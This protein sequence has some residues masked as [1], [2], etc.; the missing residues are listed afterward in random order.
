M[1]PEL[2]RW[3]L[4]EG[5]SELERKLL[6][7]GVDVEPPTGAER[8]IWQALIAKLPPPGGGTGTGPDPTAAAGT[9]GGAAAGAAGAAGIAKALLMGLA[10]GAVVAAGVGLVTPKRTPEA[11]SVRPSAQPAAGTVAVA[12]PV[13]ERANDS[14]AASLAPAPAV[15]LAANPRNVP[16]APS[17][18][19]NTVPEP[20]VA[21]PAGSAQPSSTASFAPPAAPPAQAPSPAPAERA[22]VLQAESEFLRTARRALR[23]G[24]YRSALAILNQ[25]R[26]RFPNAILSQEREA[27]SIEALAQSGARDEA[28]ARARRFLSEHPD[29]PHRSAVQELSR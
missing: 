25:S 12:E 28:R 18:P 4:D 9:S 19:E 6:I 3:L 1:K 16:I 2:K 27:L 23:S 22:S 20:V 26:A 13:A 11:T 29:S 7:S 14:P 17:A 8:E 21:E 5:R 15:P 24:D 10:A